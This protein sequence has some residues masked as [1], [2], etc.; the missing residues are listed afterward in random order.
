MWGLVYFWLYFTDCETAISEFFFGYDYDNAIGS[1]D[2]V[3]LSEE[4]ISALEIRI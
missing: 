2:P 1:R 4:D 3:F